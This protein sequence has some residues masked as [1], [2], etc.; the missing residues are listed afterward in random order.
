MRTL[1]QISQE[2]DIKLETLRKR[3]FNL[4][5]TPT[6]K[7]EKSKAFLFNENQIHSI[8]NYSEKKTIYEVEV[9]YH[10]QT[11][12]IYQSKMNYDM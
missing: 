1:K 12:Y 4:R 3:A 9:I 2:H 10:T 5:L 7:V 11:F 6:G 8:V